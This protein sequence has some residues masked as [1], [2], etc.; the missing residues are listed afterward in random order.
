MNEESISPEERFNKAK[1][2]LKTK[3]DKLKYIKERIIAAKKAN[4]KTRLKIA[5]IDHEICQLDIEKY[6]KKMEKEKIRME[7]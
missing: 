5:M 6:K 1:E 7:Q 3:V 2:A 4:N